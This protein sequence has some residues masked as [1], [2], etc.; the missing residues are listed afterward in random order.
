M[1]RMPI[2]RCAAIGIGWRGVFLGGGVLMVDEIY[3][4]L[5]YGIET[6]ETKLDERLATGDAY[7]LEAL[8]DLIVEYGGRVLFWMRDGG[9]VRLL[10]G[11]SCP[12]SSVPEHA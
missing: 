4:G 5:V 1:T 11:L 6:D 10:V 3:Q 2:L 7:L 12:H 9:H 8:R